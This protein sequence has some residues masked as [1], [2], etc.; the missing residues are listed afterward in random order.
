MERWVLMALEVARRLIDNVWQ[1]VVADE[2]GGGG[3]SS[4]FLVASATLT[5]AQILTLP[6]TPVEVIAPTEILD[7]NSEPTSL[8]Y[9]VW[10]AGWMLAHGDVYN[11]LGLAPKLMLVHGSDW[12]SL[13]ALEAELVAADPPTLQLA[14]IGF[15]GTSSTVSFIV[16]N[17]PEQGAAFKDNGLYVALDAPGNLTDGNAADTLTI[18]VVY[19]VS[20]RPT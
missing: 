16:G 11:N 5:H 20:T 7:Y 2:A 4:P 18:E 14:T 17:N 15:T 3:G 8:P 19:R 12:S 10:A 9:P 13:V 1:T 6:S